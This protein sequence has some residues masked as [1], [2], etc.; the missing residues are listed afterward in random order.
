MSNSKSENA[1]IVRTLLDLFFL[2]R[3]PS[4][5]RGSHLWRI[6]VFKLGQMRPHSVGGGKRRA[7]CSR[8]GGRGATYL[9]LTPWVQ[10][11]GEPHAAAWVERELVG[12][13]S[14]FCRCSM[15]KGNR[16][17]KVCVDCGW[18]IVLDKQEF[19]LRVKKM[20]R[21]YSETPLYRTRF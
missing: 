17:N 18:W 3:A 10:V 12:P 11:K 16:E 19:N 21:M 9:A 4:I 20:F 5:S 6:E 1:S 7:S 14:L 2:L 13:H 15:A 8:V